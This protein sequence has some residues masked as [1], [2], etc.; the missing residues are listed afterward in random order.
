[1][2]TLREKIKAQRGGSGIIEYL[3][4]DETIVD[5]FRRCFKCGNIFAACC[6]ASLYDFIF[7]LIPGWSAGQ[8]LTVD[9]PY[10]NTFGN[11]QV[12][13]V[14]A[15]SILSEDSGTIWEYSVEASTISYRD[16]TKTLFFQPKKSRSKWTEVSRLLTA[17]ILT[18]ILI[19]KL[20][21]WRLKRSRWTGAR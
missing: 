20:I 12:T 16:K 11:F 18:T 4:E 14:S 6:A 13:S 2:E 8:L 3:I 7:P 5:F 15:K 9:L 19:F 1:M 10:F 17:S 21:L